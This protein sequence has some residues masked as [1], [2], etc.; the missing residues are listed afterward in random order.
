MPASLLAAAIAGATRAQ[1]A[2]TH[3][4]ARTFGLLRLLPKQLQAPVNAVPAF[5]S[6]P[7]PNAHILDA[8]WHEVGQASDERGELRGQHVVEGLRAH[9]SAAAQ[10]VH[11]LACSRAHGAAALRA[12]HPAVALRR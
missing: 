4:A 11:A 8:I 7:K 3:A 10:R 9:P 1:S 6:H 12:A 5:A 2:Q